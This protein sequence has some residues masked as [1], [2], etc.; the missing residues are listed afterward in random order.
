MTR[1]IESRLRKLETATG[2]SQRR[3]FV[4]ESEEKRRELIASGVARESDLFINTGV[5]RSPHS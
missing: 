2:S 5:K 4:F 1:A 3:M